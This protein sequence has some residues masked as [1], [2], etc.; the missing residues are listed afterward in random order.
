MLTASPTSRGDLQSVAVKKQLALVVVLTT[1]RSSGPL[2]MWQIS[3]SCQ[4]SFPSAVLALT[5]RLCCS[6]FLSYCCFQVLAV[7]INIKPFK[8]KLA[9]EDVRCYSVISAIK[10]CLLLSL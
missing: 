4:L 10:T 6:L 7:L 3:A 8:D 1:A 5:L 9:T 2:K